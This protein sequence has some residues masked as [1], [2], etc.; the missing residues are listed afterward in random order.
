MED[1]NNIGEF[2]NFMLYSSG[3]SKVSVQVLIDKHH[4]TIWATQ[5]SIAELFDVNKSSV[6][7]HI[8]N[9]YKEGE[10][11]KDMTVAKFATVVNRGIRGS[12]T[13][14]IDYYNLDVIISV[15]YRIS[16]Y[17]AT[18]FRIWAFVR[19]VFHSVDY[20][21]NGVMAS[22]IVAYLVD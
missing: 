13:E 21:G 16:N 19:S 9:I 15:G 5:K 1:N 4:N 12:V 2:S 20:R 22:E 18:Q 17:K 7:R 14:Y 10:L 6:S 11:S 8:S 3:E